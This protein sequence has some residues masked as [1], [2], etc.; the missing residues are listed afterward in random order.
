MSDK[1]K[2]PEKPLVVLILGGTTTVAR[3]LAGYLLDNDERKASF[4][5]I[6]DRFSVHPPSTY[7]DRFFLDLLVAPEGSLEYKQVNLVNAERHQEV[8]TPPTD[9]KGRTINHKAFDVVYDLTALSLAQSA[10]GLANKP[11]AYVRLT[12]PFYEMKSLS[13]SSAGH[14]ESAELR[15]DGVRGRWWHET[16]RGIGKVQG[17]NTGV[18]RSGAFYGPGIWEETV[19]PRLVVGHVY[20]SLNEEMKFLHNSDLRIH[21]VHAIDVAQSLYLLSLYLLSTTREK[22]ILQSGVEIPFSFS[23]PPTSTFSLG[24]NKRNSVSEIWKTVKSVIPE[25]IPVTLPLFNVIDD[26]D[27]TQE[28]LAKAVAGVWDIKYGFLNSTVASLVQQFAKT[29]FLEMVEDVNEKHV[30]AWSNM[31]AKSSTPIASSPITP[32]LDEHA[33]RKHAICLDGS[34]SRRILGFKPLHPR[35]E[36]GELQRIVH[37]FQE[38]KLW[39]V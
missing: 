16:L 32:Y 21:C 29:D 38:A 35:I 19:V 3:T 15:P 13:G 31:L 2:R 7:L 30:E 20:K 5:R 14:A 22:V 28:A 17:L 12:F 27:T 10:A 24:A 1:L 39:P 9:W 8:F 23:N 37:G 18:I 11:K 26:G 4:V 25:Q 33:F 36:V 6:A 34:K